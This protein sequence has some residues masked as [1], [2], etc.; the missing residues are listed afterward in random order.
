MLPDAICKLFEDDEARAKAGSDTKKAEI[1]L[2]DAFKE[3]GAVGSYSVS[4]TV[5][6]G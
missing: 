5:R 3:A 6:K 2:S 4:V 1:V